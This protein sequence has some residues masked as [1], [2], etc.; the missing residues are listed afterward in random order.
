MSI[1]LAL[2]VID[3]RVVTWEAFLKVTGRPRSQSFRGEQCFGRTKQP[4]ILRRRIEDAN[5]MHMD[6]MH[7]DDVNFVARRYIGALA[8]SRSLVLPP[9]VYWSRRI[10]SR[11]IALAMEWETRYGTMII[12]PQVFILM[13]HRL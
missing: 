12:I 4:S 10:I 2:T 9:E 7:F 11:S 1:V 6:G 8:G 5:I 3:W 13:M